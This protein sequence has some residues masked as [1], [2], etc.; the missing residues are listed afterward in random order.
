MI[1]TIQFYRIWKDLYMSRNTSLLVSF[2]FVFCLLGPHWRHM[3]VPRHMEVGIQRSNQ[4]CRCR[5]TPQ[6]QQCQIRP[7]S[8]TYTT[9]HGNAVSLTH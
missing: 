6:P 2:F 5:P 9:A 7:A 8:A 4:S 1:I 3:E